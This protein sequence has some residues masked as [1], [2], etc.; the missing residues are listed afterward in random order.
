MENKAINIKDIKEFT[1][2]TALESYINS[3]LKE[4]K[5]EFEEKEKINKLLNIKMNEEARR[6]IVAQA[7][8]KGRKSMEKDVL[9]LIDEIY[10]KLTQSPLMSSTQFKEE[11]KTKTKLLNQRE[12]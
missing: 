8:Y 10:Y 9:G 5:E 4:Q 11:L 1:N 2:F 7:Q 3:L 12:E 6:Q